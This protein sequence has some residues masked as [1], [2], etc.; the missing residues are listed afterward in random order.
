MPSL[1]TK[2]LLL[3]V[4][5]VSLRVSRAEFERLC[6]DNPELRLELTANGELIVM[7]PA[8]GKSSRRNAK[9]ATDVA[10]WNSAAKMS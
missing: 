5:H 2:P 10:I 8:G 1:E 7:P 6:Q 9:L 4:C 3:D